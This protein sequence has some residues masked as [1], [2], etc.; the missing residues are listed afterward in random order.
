MDYGSYPHDPYDE[1]YAP[2]RRRINYFAWTVAILLLTGFALAAWL[3]SFYIFNQ[4]ERPDSYRILQRLHKIEPPKRF[5]LTAAPAGE[6]L[7]PQ[8]LYERYV[9]M[10][11]AELARTNAELTRNYIRNYQQVRGLVPYVV[12]R[13]TI[14]ATRQ[15]GPGDVFTSGMVALTHAIDN[16]QL[17]MEHLY[18]ASPEA[19]PLMK[20]TLN[21]GLEIKLERT[22]DISAVI[23]AERLVDGRIMITAVPL[24]YGSYTVTRGLGT[25]RL[26][27]PLSLNLAAGWPVLKSQERG[28]I[29]QRYAEY[30]QKIAATQQG[31]PVPIPGVSQSATPP[32]A[33][34]ELV[35]VE[36][37]RP[38]QT[39]SPPPVLAKNEKLAKATPLPKGKK[40]KKQKLESPPPAS[41]PAAPVVA[42]KRGAPSPTPI[43]V[44]S[45]RTPPPL[46]PN[47]AA[48][49]P[50]PPPKASVA[51]PVAGGQPIAQASPIPTAT[52]VPVLPA[53][54]A[55][56]DSSN[57]ALASNA[58][59]GSW[60]TFPPGKMPLGR[61]IGTGDLRDVAEHGLA[62]ER[63]YLKGQF[64]VNFSDANRAVLRPRTKLTDK[65]LHFGGGS[66]TRI[67]VEFPGGYR[68]PPQG[69]VVNRDEL[70]PYEITEVR[71]Q[72]DGQLNV[73]VR[74]IMQPN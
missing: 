31:G 67:I 36:Q 14:V 3:G 1:P 33:Q 23:H 44:A 68:P 12:G 64:V 11:S 65:V 9:G 30:R 66:S 55:P 4:P 13:Y 71:K 61:L 6:F 26:E 56:A 52:P 47:V 57:V 53:Q 34:N 16:G 49:T 46:V 5:E 74:E 60:K 50:A 27:P 73:F 2:P 10:G 17:L 70:R 32:P 63:V 41:T 43:A 37:A 62:G 69:A 15:L 39:F 21:V 59:G 48:V 25:F 72:E 51:A 35:R 29:E 54:P 38:V 42:Q 28:P 18:P 22:H 45:A 7:N 40:G 24:L 20:Q 19:L 58:G 8:Q